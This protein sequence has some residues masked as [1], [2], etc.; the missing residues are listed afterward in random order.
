MKTQVFARFKEI[1]FA[2]PYPWRFSIMAWVGLR[3]FYAL[4]SM[5]ILTLFPLSVQNFEYEDTPVVSI[6]NLETSQANLYQ[7]KVVTELLT[8]RML[9]R[10][11]ILDEQ[12]DS[13]WLISTGQSVS[14][15]FTGQRLIRSDVSIEKIFPYL[16]VQPYPDSFL[17]IWQRF[18]TNWYLSIAAHGYGKIPGD[19]HFPP[20]YPFFISLIGFLIG[21][22]FLAALFISHLASLLVIKL[23]YDLFHAWLSPAQA[24]RALFFVLIFPASYYLFAA[25]SES[26]YF[27]FVLLFLRLSQKR[28]WLWAGICVFLAILIRLQGVALIPVMLYLMYKDKPFLRK[29]SHW[30]GIVIASGCAIAYI[31]IRYISGSTQ[32]LP[33]TEAEW[34]TRLA[35]PWETFVYAIQYLAAGNASLIDIVNLFLFL[36]ILGMLL[37]GWRKMPG[38]Y[39]LYVLL[40]MII[41]TARIVEGQPFSGMIRFSLTLFP[42]FALFSVYSHKP[43]V[44]RFIV[45]VFLIM[46]LYFSAQFWLWG[47]VA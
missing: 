39:A 1:Y 6:F 46:M 11:T 24:R 30:Q 35:F 8:F 36:F 22:L 20:L 45:F 27:L 31:F 26:L 47:W 16:G 3:L 17:S 4:W 33:T 42:L 44:R 7:R 12:T 19:E 10:N 25:Y 29:V 21:D 40:M 15:S 14:G 23:L 37:L 41:M 5:V 34:Q 32:I 28:T 9:D 43:N 13:Y 2:I 38:I 18:D